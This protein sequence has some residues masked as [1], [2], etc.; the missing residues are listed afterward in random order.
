MQNSTPRLLVAVEN[1][2]VARTLTRVAAGSHTVFRS[3]NETEIR[4]ALSQPG[5]VAMVI[6]EPVIGKLSG[7]KVLDLARDVQPQALRV[8]VSNFS[9]IALLIEGVHNGLV[10][11]ILG[12]PIADAEVRT[13]LSAGTKSSAPFPP[14][15]M[16]HLAARASMAAAR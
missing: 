1:A 9:E 2:H 6:V 10:Q 7:L 8:V 4:E 14:L 5:Q 12:S 3:A 15:Q 13:L 16:P 11:R